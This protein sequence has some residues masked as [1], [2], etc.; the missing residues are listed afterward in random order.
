MK[1]VIVIVLGLLFVSPNQSQDTPRLGD[2]AVVFPRDQIG[3]VLKD[4]LPGPSLSGG[5]LLDA[6]H[7]RIGALHRKAPG[8]VE[9]HRDDTDIFYIIAG[10]ATIVTGGKP[11]HPKQTSGNETTADSIE[12]GV[13]HEIR[14]G[15]VMV[16]PKQQPHWF[17]RVGTGT[18][19][20]V[21]KVQ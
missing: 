18:E 17:Q 6:E 21:I 19:Y 8:D 2:V 10:S 3:K 11:V 12:G 4:K 13:P 16:I 15:D 5:G 1:W 7:F 9:I 20:L 14:A